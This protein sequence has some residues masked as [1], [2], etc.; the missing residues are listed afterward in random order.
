MPTPKVAIKNLRQFLWQSYFCAVLKFYCHQVAENI[1]IYHNEPRDDKTVR[2]VICAPS[3]LA[4][5]MMTAP[6]TA[7]SS[8]MEWNQSLYMG[9][10]RKLAMY[11]L[12]VL[13][14]REVIGLVEQEPH[15]LGPG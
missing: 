2:S 10:Y 9:A 1:H 7:M 15:H 5:S 12:P 6:V 8:R 3:R 11:K 4:I 13:L 14:S